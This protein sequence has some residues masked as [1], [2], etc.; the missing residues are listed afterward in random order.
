[1][2]TASTDGSCRLWFARASDLLAYAQRLDAN[3]FTE[4]DRLHCA[5]IL[6]RTA[7]PGN[8][9]ITAMDDANVCNSAVWALV[10]SGSGPGRGDLAHA[11]TLAQRSVDLT[12]GN[13]AELLNSLGV[14]LCRSGRHAEA[15]KPLEGADALR[16]KV[17]S[18]RSVTDHAFVAIA[19][20]ERGSKYDPRAALEPAHE[21]LRAAPDD[22]SSTAAFAETEAS[23]KRVPDGTPAS[24]DRGCTPAKSWRGRNLVMDRDP[25]N[26]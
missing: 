25:G 8:I 17:K 13:N 23:L 14:A 26:T 15:V 5:D 22:A 2:L 12:H 7:T 16:V 11:V 9:E 4:E 21:L 1:M 18:R 20:P 6:G 19:R 24:P 10:E 3:K